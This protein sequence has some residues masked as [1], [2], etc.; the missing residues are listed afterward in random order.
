M[1]SFALATILMC[2]C[3]GGVTEDRIAAFEPPVPPANAFMLSTP[4]I[5][6]IQPG[7]SNEYCTW[8]DYTADADLDLRAISAYQTFTGHHVVLYTTGKHKPAG[9]THICTEDD[10]VTF[11]Y[12]A[13]AGGEGNDWKNEAPGEL[14]YR[15]PA[16]QQLVLNHHYLNASPRTIDA[17]SALTLYRAE[18]GRK[19]TPVG[20]LAF[21][22]TT[23]SIPAG[24]PSLD[25][26]CPLDRSFKAWPM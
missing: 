13:V 20:S 14:V 16:G 19:L 10:M 24:R 8:T 25:I 23:L 4:P 18:T 17:Q 6:D 5:R 2:G 12:I 15:I 9:T 3:T 11:R 7:S 21:V 1:R 26:H 22:D